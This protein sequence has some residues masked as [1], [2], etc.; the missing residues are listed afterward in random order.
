MHYFL[1]KLKKSCPF[2]HL[3][4]LLCLHL[5]L[6]ALLYS[7]HEDGSPQ[8]YTIGTS[9][10]DKVQWEGIPAD[11][12]LNYGVQTSSALRIAMKHPFTVSQPADEESCQMLQYRRQLRLGYISACMP[13]DV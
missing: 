8:R 13:F 7:T 5:N 11:K 12:H 3:S 6:S 2:L 10:G 1:L 4:I 9:L